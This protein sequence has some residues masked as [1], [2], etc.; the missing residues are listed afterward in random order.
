MVD[1]DREQAV[2]MAERIG[3]RWFLSLDSALARGRFGAVDLMLPHD[4]H[5]EAAE[6]CFAAGKHVL[7]EKPMAPDLAG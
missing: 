6:T 7:L 4:R 2:T 5:V 3:C 1:T